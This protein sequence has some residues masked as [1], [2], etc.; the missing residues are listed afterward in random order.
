MTRF[1]LSEHV[2]DGIVAV[3]ARYGQVEKAGVYGSRAQGEYRFNSDVDIAIYAPNMAEEDFFKLRF[4]LRELPLVFSLDIC[5]VDT[6]SNISLK[7]KIQQEA[8][9]IYQQ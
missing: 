1:G 9:I 5:H 3:V 7:Q 2:I 4:E 8:V 6:L